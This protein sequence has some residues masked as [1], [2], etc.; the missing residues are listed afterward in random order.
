LHEYGITSLPK[1]P[2]DKSF[3]AVILA[4]AHHEFL[5]IDLEKLKHPGTIVYD[6]KGILDISLI[7]GRL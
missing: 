5:T 1:M 6:V 4:V 7:N 3:D 2:E